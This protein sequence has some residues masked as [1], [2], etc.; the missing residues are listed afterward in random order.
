MIQK[1][2]YI[3]TLSAESMN[4]FFTVFARCVCLIWAILLAAGAPGQQKSLMIGIDGLGFG[5]SGFSAADTPWMDSLIQGTFA[6]GTY[7]G[8]YTD[9]AYAG[10]LIGSPTVQ[11]TVSGPGWSTI[12]TGVWAD[13]HGVFDNNFSGRDYV[14][15]PPYLETL[16]TAL[17]ELTT[18]SFINWDP[19]DTFIIAAIDQDAIAENDMD[20]RGIYASDNATAA[21]A[22]AAISDVN[23]LDPDAIFVAFD[24]VDVAGHTCGSSG[25]CYQIEIEQADNLV[26]QLLDALIHRPDFANEDWQIVITSDHG[27]TAA[28]GHG[29]QTDLERRIPFIV[30]GTSVAPG[31]LVDALKGVSHADVAPTVLDHFGVEIPGHYFGVS[32]AAGGLLGN[33]DIN[34]DGMVNGDGTGPAG[35]DDVTAFISYWLQSSPPGTTPLPADLNF[36]GLVSLADWGI[37]NTAGPNL[38]RAVLAAIHDLSVP[39]PASWMLALFSA[40]LGTLLIHRGRRAC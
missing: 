30:A 15:N 12:L 27:H 38:G 7:R 19:I 32:R 20:F 31:R 29:G 37:L 23:G 35:L 2:P 26:G 25:A 33:P 8:A 40:V 16:K 28:G 39:E 24:E 10:G 22:F 18:A 1:I 34:G 13:R 5:T 11:P 21:A 17:P 14:N 3:R 6:G 36:D 9:A 4:R